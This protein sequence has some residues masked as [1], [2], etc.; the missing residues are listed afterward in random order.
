MRFLFKALLAATALVPVATAASAQDDRSGWRHGENRADERQVR[1]RGERTH[2]ERDG[3]R[4]GD[5]GVGAPVSAD[6]NAQVRR[7]RPHV[8]SSPLQMPNLAVQPSRNGGGW[9]RGDRA[10]WVA[11]GDQRQGSPI[12]RPGDGGVYGQRDRDAARDPSAYG[13]RDRAG[14]YGQRDRDVTR[15]NGAF[16]QRDR[17]VTRADGAY[18]RRDRDVTRGNGAYGQKDRDWNRNRGGNDQWRGD[19]GWRDNDRSGNRGW[20]RTWRNDRRYDWGG[21][22]SANRSAYRLPRYYAP[23]GWNSGYR[24]FSVGITLNSI[25]FDENYWIDDPYEYRL[26]EAYGP[27]R[28]VR[29]YNDALLVDVRYGQVIDVVHDIFW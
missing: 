11:R 24:R 20:N 15:A 18:G 4:G 6:G 9:N 14:A 23:Y 26:P 2:V 3:A 1:G 28:W 22:R 27:Y 12:V 19:G 7:E 17:D 8:D 29:Y 13:Q 21:Y 5:R 16:G 25:L 10:N